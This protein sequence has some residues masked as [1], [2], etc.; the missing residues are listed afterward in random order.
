M[1]TTNRQLMMPTSQKELNIP[2]KKRYSEQITLLENEDN[3]WK[4]K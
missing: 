3:G 1:S 2:M 4:M